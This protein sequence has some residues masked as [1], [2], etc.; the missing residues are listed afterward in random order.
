MEEFI[1][2]SPYQN[3]SSHNVLQY[4]LTIYKKYC[5]KKTNWIRKSVVMKRWNISKVYFLVAY[6]ISFC[7]DKYKFKM[8]TIFI[9]TKISQVLAKF[10][11]KTFQF[12]D[13]CE[14]QNIIKHWI[15]EYFFP[16]FFWKCLKRFFKRTETFAAEY[17][18]LFNDRA[19]VQWIRWI[20]LS[21]LILS[22][23]S[24]DIIAWQ[25]YI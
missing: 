14:S 16:F 12:M 9:F 3:I 21:A 13:F 15:V 2:L 18:L 22:S 7:A 1:S 20:S 17:F 10:N 24:K 5:L 6:A 4:F 23:N 11:N 19:A 8:N 25:I